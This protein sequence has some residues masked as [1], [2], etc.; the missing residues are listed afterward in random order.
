MYAEHVHTDIDDAAAMGLD[1]FALN[2]GDPTQSYVT[3]LF[4]NMFDY[5]R[6]NHPDFKLFLSMD[7]W[8]E[9]NAFNEVEIDQY[10]SLITAF[11][12]HDA[13]HRGPNG[14]P[15]FSTFSSGGMQSD[16][17]ETWKAKWSQDVYL[18]PDFDDTAGYN[19]SADAWWTY[20][21]E[22]VDGTFSWE[23]VW[24]KV[25]VTGGDG[26]VTI[27]EVVISGNVEHGKSYMMRRESSTVTL[28]WVYTDSL[29]L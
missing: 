29:K 1:G 22:V 7:L 18:V 14:K 12:D 27:D 3:D 16:E 13:Y 5:A 28:V 10:D 6:D 25:G 24:P 15:F 4:N 8:A 11:K 20:W 2:V 23:T 17:W 21:E 9:G 19:T 26:D